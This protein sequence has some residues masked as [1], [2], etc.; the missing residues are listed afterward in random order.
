MPDFLGLQPLMHTAVAT[1]PPPWA[2]GL[3]PNLG[4]SFTQIPGKGS[5]S[6]ATG[7]IPACA[8]GLYPMS[9]S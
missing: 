5:T 8:S 2:L 1:E 6:S 9:N 7:L 3:T 4:S